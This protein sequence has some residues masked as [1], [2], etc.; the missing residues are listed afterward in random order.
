MLDKSDTRWI[1]S[2]VGSLL[3]Y[4]RALDN[5]I[6]PALNTIGT[7]QAL[8]TATTKKKVQRLLDYVN[9]YPNAVLRFYA[10]DMILK[11]D[12]DAAY[13]VLPKA[14]SRFAGYFRLLDKPTTSNYQHNGAI[15]IECKSVRNV[16]SSAAEAETNGIFE[17]AKIGVNFIAIF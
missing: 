11:I 1:Q 6:L 16:V 14:R 12:S 10:S 2:A 15:L 13:L 9:I 7:E 4:G 8:P 3:Y 17:N 5:T